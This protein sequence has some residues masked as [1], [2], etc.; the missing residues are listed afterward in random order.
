[1]PTKKTLRMMVA[2]QIAAVL[3]GALAATV[4][5]PSLV[6]DYRLPADVIAVA[7]ELFWLAN[8]VLV[9][10]LLAALGLCF[11]ADIF[12]SLYAGLTATS[13]LLSSLHPSVSS[14]SMD[15]LHQIDAVLRGAIVALIYFSPLSDLF[16]PGPQRDL[17]SLQRLFRYLILAQIPLILITIVGGFLSGARHAQVVAINDA[18]DAVHPG[19]GALAGISVLAYIVVNICLYKFW[20]A[21]R[22]AYLVVTVA[23]VL[24]ALYLSPSVSSAGAEFFTTGITIVNGALLGLA[25]FSPLSAVFDGPATT[26]AAPPTPAPAPI[27]SPR[28]AIPPSIEPAVMSPPVTSPPVAS[29]AIAPP[30]PAPVIRQPVVAPA[31]SPLRTRFCGECGARVDEAKFCSTCGHRQ[32]AKDEC[33]GCGGKLQAGSRFCAECGAQV[34]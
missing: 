32:R 11:F 6:R 24:E 15:F 22:G 10:F 21:S 31:S 2:V 18:M 5:I 17:Q 33:A 23:A 8:L 7:P 1:M 16:K 3:G 34:V 27:I 29:A 20:R 28:V 25:Y 26:Q 13:L 30:P 4:S 14:G 12:R 19:R 9:A